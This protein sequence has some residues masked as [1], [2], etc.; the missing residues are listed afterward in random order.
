MGD[1]RRNRCADIRLRSNLRPGELE[2]P[3]VEFNAVIVRAAIGVIG[4]D[5][6]YA[7]DASEIGLLGA[8][9]DFR[10]KFLRALAHFRHAKHEIIVF[11][12]WDPDELDFPFRQWTRFASLETPSNRHLVD[13][14]QMRRSYLEKLAQFREQ[15][16]KGCSRHRISLVPLTTNQPYA[17]SLAAYLALRRKSA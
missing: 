3:A 1:L 9:I 10:Q 16:A 11:Q 5:R 4:E 2:D 7:H 15:L 14:A 17:D 13:P 12:I 6:A 8:V